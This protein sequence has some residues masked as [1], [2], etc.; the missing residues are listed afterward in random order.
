MFELTVTNLMPTSSHSKL[1]WLCKTRWV[2]R[3]TCFDVFLELYE[4]LGSPHQYPELQ[5]SD[6]YWKW[7]SETT[8]RAQGLKASLSSFQMIATFIIT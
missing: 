6:G 1:P 5:S 7:D 8:V 4:P 2:E 3:H